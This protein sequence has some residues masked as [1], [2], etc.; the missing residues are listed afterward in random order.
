MIFVIG[1][2]ILRVD[3]VIK[4]NGYVVEFIIFFFTIM[5]TGI[6]LIKEKWGSIGS[7]PIPLF[8]P[9]RWLVTLLTRRLP[10]QWRSGA[11]FMLSRGV[12]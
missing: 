6:T 7:F 3:Y 12:S 9:P 11:R 4:V 8:E 2:V 5:K 10:S 1:G